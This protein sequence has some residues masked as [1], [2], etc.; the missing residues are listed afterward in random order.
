[1]K[2]GP[3]PK[4]TALKELAGNPGHRPLNDAE[5]VAPP[6]MPDCPAQ[7]DDLAKDLWKQLAPTLHRMMVLKQIDGGILAAYCQ[8]YSTWLQATDKVKEDGILVKINGQ[9]QPNG[10][11]GIMHKQSEHM[12]KLGAELGLSPSS[13]TRLRVDPADKPAS[14]LKALLDGEPG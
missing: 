5:P 12:R 3:R 7:L 2:R 4:P 1:M 9:P 10:Y 13:R 8:A 14:G 6:E 11:L